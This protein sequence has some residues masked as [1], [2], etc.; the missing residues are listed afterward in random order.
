MMDLDEPSPLRVDRRVKEI[1]RR[2]AGPPGAG[3]NEEVL[4]VATLV[5]SHRRE[6]PLR[7][8]VV[9]TAPAVV[10]ET[11]PPVAT[12]RDATGAR[13]L[14]WNVEVPA[15]KPVV[16]QMRYRAL[17]KP[18]SPAETAAPSSGEKKQP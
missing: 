13:R 9:C 16:L 3:A 15:G 4:A 7:A 11:V 2:P 17:V 6:T 10:E 5:L 1:S 12:E 14:R 8:S 18:L